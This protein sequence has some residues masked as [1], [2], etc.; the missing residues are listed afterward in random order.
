LI[1][2]PLVNG[3]RRSKYSLVLRAHAPVA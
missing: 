2:V 3:T 1:V